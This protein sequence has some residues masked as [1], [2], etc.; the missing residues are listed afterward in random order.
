MNVHEDINRELKEMGVCFPE[1][2]GGRVHSRPDNYFRNFP[3]EMLEQVRCAKTEAGL[4][5]K[6]PFSLPEGYFDNF[7]AILKEKWLQIPAAEET[8][9]LS[10]LLAGLKDKSTYT[11]PEENYF[12]V[13]IPSSNVVPFPSEE[14]HPG[15]RRIKWMRWVAAV[16]VVC[17]LSL[18]GFTFLNS[19]SQAAL[20]ENNIEAA[21]AS[22]PDEVIQQYLNDNMDT[23]DLYSNVT[24]QPSTVQISPNEEELLRGI[25]DKE[26]ERILE[27]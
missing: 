11:H 18:G 5:K 1:R 6:M 12:E 27:D 26:I 15:E 2:V 4:S 8:E 24:E 19:G 25:S 16:T 22:I 20:P 21:L 13:I 10:P 7:E 23:Y 17:I 3:E 14:P 9:M